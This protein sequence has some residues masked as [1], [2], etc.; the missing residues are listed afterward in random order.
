M[1]EQSQYVILE[2]SWQGVHWDLMIEIE[3]ALETWAID[4]PIVSDIDLS[5]RRL[6][7][8]R[9]HYLDHEGAVSN[10]RGTVRR[11]D[12]G[13]CLVRLWTE[14]NVEVCLEGERLSCVVRLERQPIGPTDGGR[15]WLLR[16]TGKVD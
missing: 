12:K 5:A 2:H 14:E 8:H 9:L 16:F 1:S 10:N 11:F 13:L 6:D 4:A 15:C 3:G 7:R